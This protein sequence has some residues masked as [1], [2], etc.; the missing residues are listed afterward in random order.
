[1][2]Q[3]DKVVRSNGRKIPCIDA[4]T[5]PHSGTGYLYPVSYKEPITQFCHAGR[6]GFLFQI[7]VTDKTT[8]AKKNSSFI[9]HERWA[10]NETAVYAGPIEFNFGSTIYDMD[11]FCQKISDLMNN[12]PVIGVKDICVDL[13]TQPDLEFTLG[14]NTDGDEDTNKSY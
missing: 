14:T 12:I 13:D 8:G 5:F 10:G 6:E 11:E 4:T 2:Q 7:V 9:V 1:M 3:I